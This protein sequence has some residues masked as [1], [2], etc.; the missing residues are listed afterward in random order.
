MVQDILL[1]VDLNDE[2]SWPKAL[3]AAIKMAKTSG[4]P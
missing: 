2:D 3:P 1:T 4:A